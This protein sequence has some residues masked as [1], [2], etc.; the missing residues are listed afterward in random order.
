MAGL[1]I[2]CLQ[3]WEPNPLDDSTARPWRTGML[4][5]RLAQAGHDVTWWAS[6]FS[7]TSKS[8][9]SQRPELELP[10]DL[11]LIPALGY[12]RHVS[13][14]RL[15]DHKYVAD[16]WSA[17][18]EAETKPDVIVA[19]YPTIETCA[20][21]A[22]YGKRHGV[23]VLMDI[24]DQYPDLYWLNA[25]APMRSL[26]RM[27]SAGARQLAK[28]AL[29]GATG[30]TANGP[31]VVDWGLAYAGRARGEFDAS[32]FMSY[33]PPTVSP[34]DA[35]RAAEYWREL[36]ID[37][38]HNH[39][40]ITYTGMIGQTV[41]LE[42]IFRAAAALAGDPQVRFVMCGGGDA[43]D[44]AKIRAANLSNVLFTG[45]LKSPE[46]Q[47][48]L[49]L[50]QVGLVPYRDRA[51][52]ETGITNKP[53]EYFAN[54][55]PVVTSLRRG[56]LVDMIRKTAAGAT[57]TNADPDSLAATLRPWISH[58]TSLEGARTSARKLFD[59]NF[60]PD[61]VYGRWIELIERTA[62]R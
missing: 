44:E 17:L 25:P 31:D 8:F 20:A 38:G 40:L 37:D 23:P 22:D 12:R 59:Q 19:S 56:V 2:W 51:N 62:R 28:R 57:Y 60:H 61:I 7:H 5:A 30:I 53:V 1:K 41:E 11:K 10:Y 48:I 9:R 16:Q 42:P 15:R 18:A 47:R 54:S 46:I 33:E 50:S 45:W 13:L 34:D 21:A 14:A 35:T 32:L 36:G 43:L 52:F 55:L 58:T 26:V 4:A 49:Q 27:V 24:R 29:G 39:F 3:T 6:H